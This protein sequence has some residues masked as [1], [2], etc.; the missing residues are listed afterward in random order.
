[1]EMVSERLRRPIVGVSWAI[2]PEEGAPHCPREGLEAR[3][4]SPFQ[5][6]FIGPR[7]CGEDAGRERDSLCHSPEGRALSS[8]C[9][10]KVPSPELAKG[11][12]G[13]RL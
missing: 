1:M 10:Q 2:W 5:A 11:H 9:F 8:A 3:E 6:H 4:G 12:G 7:A 13:R